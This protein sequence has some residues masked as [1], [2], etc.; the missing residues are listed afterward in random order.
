MGFTLALSP[1]TL[2]VGEDSPEVFVEDE[3]MALAARLSLVLAKHR[4]SGSH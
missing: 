3:W 1:A 2:A 4:F